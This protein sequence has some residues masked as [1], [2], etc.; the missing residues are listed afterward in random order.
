MA[1]TSGRGGYARI[2]GGSPTAVAEPAAWAASTDYVRDNV[3][4]VTTS[5]HEAYALCIRPHN[6]SASGLEADANGLDRSSPDIANWREIDQGTITA[7][8][9]WSFTTS[10]TTE[11]EDYVIESA[12]R[13]VG[14]QLTTTVELDFADDSGPGQDV[15]QN[16]IVTGNEFQ[17]ELY[18]KG[19]GEGLPMYS[20]TARV[21]GDAG[22]FSTST[23]TRTPT[24][25]IQGAWTRTVQS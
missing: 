23:Q 22:A 16:A 10:E 20:G 18:P 4:K 7:L 3:V 25:N 11:N 1:R 15:V 2:T 14:T 24:L 9:S 5:T 8:R 19:K 12:S 13:T 21:G 17:L 6:S